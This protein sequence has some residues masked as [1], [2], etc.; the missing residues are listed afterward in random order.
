M[1]ERNVRSTADVID[2]HIACRLAN[3][4]DGDLARNYSDQVVILTSDGARYGEDGIRH[5]HD[6]LRRTVPSDYSIVSRLTHGPYGFITWRA[7]EPGK[8]VEDGADS[9]VVEAGRI[10][11]Q[12]IHYSV[13]Q[14]M[15]P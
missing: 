2:D 4:I 7:R 14:V 3:D 13:Q 1:S 5:L 15:P 8:S 6:R 11:F 9:F 10:V 12:S